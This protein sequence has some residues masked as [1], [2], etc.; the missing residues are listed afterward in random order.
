MPWVCPSKDKKTEKKKKKDIEGPEIEP[1]IN[2]HS[3]FGKVVKTIQQSN[4]STNGRETIEH[5][6][7]KMKQFILYTQKSFVDYT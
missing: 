7:V 5:L 6:D 1:C 4:N 2:E 3:I